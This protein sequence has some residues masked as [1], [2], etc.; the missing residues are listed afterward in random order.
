MQ[1]AD[2][3]RS[4]AQLG[5]DLLGRKLPMCLSDIY[6][7]NLLFWYRRCFAQRYSY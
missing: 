4:A 3:I 5:I 1:H 2:D 7:I 6:P